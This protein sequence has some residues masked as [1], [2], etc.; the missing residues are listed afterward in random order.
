ME[1]FM[2]YK[3]KAFTLIELIV[4]MAIVAIMMAAIMKFFEPIRMVYNDAT[5]FEQRR[6]VTNSMVK[7]TTESIRYAKY[8]GIF[9][10]NDVGARPGTVEEQA[11]QAAGALLGYMSAEAPPLKPPVGATINVIE[12]N[13]HNDVSDAYING[14]AY[15]GRLY[16]AKLRY[17]GTGV[18]TD[19]TNL[20]LAFGKEYYG[21]NHYFMQ[22]AYKGGKFESF[23]ATYPAVDGGLENSYTV[24]DPVRGDS[25]IVRSVAAVNLKNISGSLNPGKAFFKDAGPADGVPDF[26]TDSS[27]L[28]TDGTAIPYGGMSATAGVTSYYLVWIDADQF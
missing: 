25:V 7:Y 12:L 5:Y 21:A 13:Y 3:V 14:E 27:T 23:A 19:V 4:V 11:Q 10:Q 26:T 16:R 18:G 20:H 6:S 22:W 1:L 8:L 9:N 15:N 17:T 28:T 24:S 2:K